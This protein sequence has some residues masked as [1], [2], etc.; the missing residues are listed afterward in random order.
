MTKAISTDES[1]GIEMETPEKKE[2]LRKP[3]K[4][5]QYMVHSNA[6]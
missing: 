5:G 6:V 1:S 4:Q 2:K 3:W